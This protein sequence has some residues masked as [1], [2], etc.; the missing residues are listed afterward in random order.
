M[1]RD[2]LVAEHVVT[3]GERGRDSHAPR[4]VVGDH[5]VGRPVVGEANAVDL[6]PLE[7]GL[8]GGRA[9]AIALGDVGEHGTDVAFGPLGP[10]EVD[11][12]AGLDGAGGGGCLGVLV[13]DDVGVGVGVG[14]DE[15]VVEV[16]GGPGGGLRDLLA[17][18]GEV[19]GRDIVALVVGAVGEVAGDGAVGGSGGRKGSDGK[20]G[21]HLDCWKVDGEVEGGMVSFRKWRSCC[22]EKECLACFTR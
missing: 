3:R 13:A 11:L 17:L 8:V 6:D 9:L 16:L 20:D 1:Q 5:L 21:R 2:G 18:L 4:V 10:L 22:S 12:A 14:G 19:E 7:R 15:A